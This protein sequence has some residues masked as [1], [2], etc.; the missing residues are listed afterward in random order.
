[1]S[2]NLHKHRTNS[3]P[4]RTQDRNAVKDVV[5]LLGLF[6]FSLVITLPTIRRLD[7]W[8]DEIAIILQLNLSFAG[9]WEFN[10][11]ENFPPLYSWLLKI[12]SLI[13]NDPNWLRLLSA[14]LG[15]AIAPMAYLLGKESHSRKLGLLLGLAIALSLP[16]TYFS[17]VVRMYTLYILAVTVSYY[18]FLRALRTNEWKAWILVAVANTAGFYSFLFSL[19][20]IFSEFLILVWF[21]R[22]GW[23]K[24]L[25]P[26]VTQSP[27]VMLMLFWVGTLLTRYSVHQSYI[28]EKADLRSIFN[29]ITYL[30]TGDS[31]RLEQ[32]WLVILNF[33]LM[34][35]FVL[36]VKSGYKKAPQ[37]AL[38]AIVFISLGIIIV[39][40]F[41]GS[42]L[43]FDRYLLF[44]L[45]LYFYLAFYGWLETV[46]PL[47][48]RLGILWIFLS[49]VWTQIHYHTHFIGVNDEFRYHVFY[50]S[51]VQEDGH[52]SSRM[53][54]AMKE[55]WKPGEII[56]HYSR[57][58]I[59]SLS[60][61]PS[62]YYNERA[63][64]EYIYSVEEVPI[65]CGQQYLKP[66]E[67]LASLKDL[68]PLP[69]SL[70]VI[71]WGPPDHLAYNTPVAEFIRNQAQPWIKKEDLPRELYDTGYRPDD[72]IGIAGI[73]AVHFRRI[74]PSDSVQTAGVIDL[75]NLSF[76]IGHKLRQR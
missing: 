43:I 4:Y 52:S 14:L 32:L 36:G 22:R 45:P 6:L 16:V 62:I 73:T 50:R 30:G 41:T 15:A 51:H 7:V 37:F 75:S 9:I 5:I 46:R 71:T 53:A 48:R 63:L 1:M 20:V 74:N 39:K 27:A 13:S 76:S 10:K 21:Y 17:Q 55:R 65:F 70:W 19:F 58:V 40:S 11:L 72:A 60:F 33:P 8:F 25:R 35:G 2:L 68:D 42:T 56:I 44:L 47:W 49:L 31:F 61:F 69:E 34:V 38:A 26:L 28:S 18:A 57:D 59:R 66:H 12:W 3:D 23:R 67:R 24:Y 64:P 54:A 29:A